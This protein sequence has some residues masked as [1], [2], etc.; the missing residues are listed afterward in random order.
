MGR[1]PQKILFIL[2]TFNYEKI[3]DRTVGNSRNTE[4]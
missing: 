2:K 1:Y 4:Q 3:L